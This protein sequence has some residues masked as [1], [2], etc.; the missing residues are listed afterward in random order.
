MQLPQ[1]APLAAAIEKLSAL[2]RPVD[3]QQALIADVVG[4]VLAADLIADRDCPA[5]DMSAMDGYALRLS[6]DL[7]ATLPVQATAA[8]GIEPLTLLPDHAIRIFTGAVVPAGAD[9]VVRREDTLEQPYRVQLTIPVGELQ[10]G[11]NIRRRGENAPQGACLLPRG[12]LVDA[13][14]IPAVAS[15]GA[16]T[17]AVYR[18]L[19][20]A[21]LNT[22]DELA[23]PGSPVAA[24]Q[25]RDSNGPTLTAWLAGLRWIE[26]ARRQRVGDTLQQVQA[27]LAAQLE[28]SDAILI[29][30]GVSMGDTD[31]VPAAIQS[32]G[33]QIVFHRLPIRPG[34]PVL[35][36]ILDGKLII[37]LPGNPVSVAVTARVVAEPLLRKM[38]GFGAAAPRLAVRLAETDSRRLDLTWFRLVTIDASGAIHLA[39][40][41]GSG[42]LVSLSL[43]HGFVEISAGADG[44]GPVPLTLW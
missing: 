35:G 3:V 29:T 19:R 39:K 26:T 43:S 5:L 33:G 20:V 6:E 28:H 42:D 36:A 38:A 12:T 34:R 41:R 7:P 10:L 17:L 27:A 24:W 21:V 8:A 37:G 40:S 1:L 9:C 18:P 15:F 25:I 22:G 44:C 23:E 14:S 32:L 16:E 13:A 31:Y 30:G 4:R 11:Q 2:L